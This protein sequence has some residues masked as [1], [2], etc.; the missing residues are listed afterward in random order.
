MLYKL[1]YAA[2]ALLDM[3]RAGL[4]LSACARLG[5]EREVHLGSRPSRFEGCLTWP[6]G[7]TQT[8]S[9][10]SGGLELNLTPLCEQ[11]WHQC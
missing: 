9:K 3:S 4:K 11:V 5:W 10:T 2:Y 8:F 6:C 7:Q 1:Q